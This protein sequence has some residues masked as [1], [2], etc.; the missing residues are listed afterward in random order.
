[1]RQAEHNQEFAKSLDQQQN[2]KFW[3]WLIT[4]A[5]Y[6]AVHY[7]EAFFFTVNAIGHT[8]KAHSQ[9]PHKFR[10]H[11]VK[12]YLGIDCWK[13]Y[14]KL[15][16]A[17]YNVRYLALATSKHKLGTATSYY[18][19]KDASTFLVVDL[20]KIQETVTKKLQ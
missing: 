2:L 3:D 12:E 8:E 1:L 6:A 5:F 13:S 17:S 7:V 11:N 19:R 20:K 4:A 16:D 18:K 9:N 10:Q 14:R 15:Q